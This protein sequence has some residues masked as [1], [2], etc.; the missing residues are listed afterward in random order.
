MTAGRAARLAIIAAP[1]ALLALNLLVIPG[2]TGDDAFI[3]F[4]YARNLAERGI[5]SYNTGAASYGSTSIL[6]VVLCAA[7]S[8]LS[9][10]VVLTGRVLCALFTIA[11]GA[12]FAEYLSST[13]RLS[14]R[15]VL[16]GLTVYLG[17]A[18]MF[19][20]M[21]TGMETGLTLFVAVLLLRSWSPGHPLRNAL[22]TLAAYL[23]R[24]EFIL[25]PVAWCL[26]LFIRRREGARR[27]ALLYVP[28]LIA[29]FAC[30]FGAASAYFHALFPLTSLKT[31]SAFD[32]ESLL[33]FAGVAAG[34]YPD[35]IAAAALLALTGRASRAA[36]RNVPPAEM[37]LFAFSAILLCT[38]ALKGTNMIS[39]YLLIIH[40]AVALLFVRLL[41]ADGSGRR[42]ARGAVLIAGAQTALFLSVH[43]GPIRSFVGGF[44]SVYASL[45][46]RIAAEPDTGAV[47]AA[48]VGMVGYYSRRP[49]ID[50]GGLTST[51]T[52]D[53]GTTADTAIVAR[54][55]PRYVIARLPSPAIDSCVAR[56]KAA[57]PALTGAAQLR[58]DRIGRL[59]VM[60]SAHDTYDVY[61]VR[62]LWAE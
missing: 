3:H 5:V 2:Y 44:Q 30:W 12:L 31:G 26:V 35:L 28:A 39:R 55:R 36:L 24:P 6:W 48:D 11:S 18:V 61:L 40:P 58:H 20:W 42:L 41:A 38:Y 59:G 62:L 34:M 16:A 22:L 15:C 19:R 10:D 52:R 1:A 43:L 53:A 56:W 17:N 9:R 27:E 54:Y 49:V 14:P 57:S 23:D 29:L 25:L 21:L 47:M 32:A 60:G 33:R 50:L 37:L 51:H 46:R 8:L 7:G 4:T 45:G 13:L